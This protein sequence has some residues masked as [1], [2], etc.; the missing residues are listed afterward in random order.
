MLRCAVFTR[1]SL[2]FGAE[3]GRDT[4]QVET[5]RVRGEEKIG[6]VRSEV[7]AAGW[8]GGLFSAL[9]SRVFRFEVSARASRHVRRDGRCDAMR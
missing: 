4:R 7:L 6:A 9:R 1:R 3:G 2:Q 5:S 8:C